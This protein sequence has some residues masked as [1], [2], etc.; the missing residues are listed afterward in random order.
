MAVVNIGGDGAVTR[1][2]GQRFTLADR[3]MPLRAHGLEGGVVRGAD[4]RF[5]I[6]SL[7]AHKACP[8]K[9]ISL[10]EAN[11]LVRGD[12]ESSNRRTP[13]SARHPR[14]VE[15]AQL[16]LGLTVLEPGSVWNTMP[17]HLHD[18]RSEIYLYFGLGET[19]RVFHYTGRAGF[20]AP[21]RH[22]Q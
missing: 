13:L 17:P 4:A 21:H 1:V 16:L 20:D 12:L 6:A 15:S 10:A 3:G 11:P 22:R 9:K 18:R 14:R 19:D 8:L 5:Y 7:P 2:D